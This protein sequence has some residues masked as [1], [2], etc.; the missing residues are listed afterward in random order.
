MGKS[1]WKAVSGNGLGRVGQ[2]PAEYQPTVCP[3]GQEGQ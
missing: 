2:Q 3:G 1:V